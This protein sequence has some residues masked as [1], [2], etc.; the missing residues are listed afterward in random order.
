L[1]AFVGAGGVTE[2]FHRAADIH[3]NKLCKVVIGINHDARAIES[4]AA[5][6]PDTIHFVEEFTTLDPKRLISIVDAAKLR[7]PN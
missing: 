2:G 3:G 4:N 7:Y 1:I 6:H 5:N